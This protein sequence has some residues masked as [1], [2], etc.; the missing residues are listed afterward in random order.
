M[1][2]LYKI[3]YALGGGF[4]GC[5]LADWEEVECDT[6]E[7]AQDLAYQEAAEIYH[8]E[9]GGSGIR[10]IQEIMEDDDCDEAA[11]EEI[12]SDDMES[13]LEYEAK[14]IPMSQRMS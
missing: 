4:G 9:A 12:Y 8:S 6:L 13:W 10:D 11:A 5:E 1:K 14:V 7:D 2:S 3:R